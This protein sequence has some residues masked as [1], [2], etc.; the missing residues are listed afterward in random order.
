MQE[1]LVRPSRTKAKLHLGAIAKTALRFS[2]LKFKARNN[3]EMRPDPDEDI[4]QIAADSSP[5][6][7]IPNG[8]ALKKEINSNE[9]E[10]SNIVSSIS[11]GT[12]S[13]VIDAP[14]SPEPERKV[15]NVEN[16]NEREIEKLNGLE[17]R[18]C[19][20]EKQVLQFK[21]TFDVQ[22]KTMLDMLGDLKEQ[23]DNK[24]IVTNVDSC[25]SNFQIE[26]A[27]SESD[28]MTSFF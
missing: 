17:N 2:F 27:A 4:D 7:S 24:E 25:R 21:N 26:T 28:T 15:E 20:I 11:M 6:L 18:I 9:N 12:P 22:M 23:M 5:G 13:I 19:R 3:L 8:H 1:G 16:R 10:P 14:I